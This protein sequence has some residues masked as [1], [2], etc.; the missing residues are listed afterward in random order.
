MRSLRFFRRVPFL[1]LTLNLALAV[2][3]RAQMSTQEAPVTE[4]SPP[5]APPASAVIPSVTGTAAL[6]GTGADKWEK[7]IAAFE[8]KDKE[9]PPPADGV[10]FAGSSTLRLWKTLAAEFPEVPVINRGFGGSR[11]PDL[12]RYADRIIIPYK[13][14]LVVVYSGG[15]DINAKKTPAELMASTVALD[16]KLRAALPDTTIVHVTLNPTIKRLEQEPQVREYNKLLAAY[17]AGK[18][19]VVF[20]DT[21]SK[22]IGPDGKPQDKL[23][24]VDKLHPSD[25]GYKRFAAAMKPAILKA[26]QDAGGKLK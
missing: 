19:K 14:R 5:P 3:L 12:T 9:T 20:I 22:M 7:E 8:A 13:P 25:E 18:P 1:S 11:M 23:L 10:V 26:Y 4:V 15:N 16:E 2:A 21:Y 17:C 24:K 6:S